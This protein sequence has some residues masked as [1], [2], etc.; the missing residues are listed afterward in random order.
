MIRQIN[1]KDI[2]QVA[3]IW[4][5]ISIDRYSFVCE[6]IGIDPREFWSNKL[7][8]MIQTTL[9][10]DG[11]V[12]QVNDQIQG[13]LTMRPED[14]CGYY[15]CELFVDSPWQGKGIV[16]EA[17]ID[18]AKSLGAYICTSAYQ[19]ADWAIRFYEKHGFVKKSEEHRIESTTNQYKF[20]LL[21]QKT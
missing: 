21:W 13:F 12:Y 19:K 2:R 3:D 10:V 16:G 11:Y 5:K 4:L 8:E 1:I 15:L 18:H 17:L 7:P 6:H 14:S 20:D 9:E